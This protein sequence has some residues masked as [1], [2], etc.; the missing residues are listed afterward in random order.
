[1]VLV[2]ET[3]YH[4]GVLVG[5]KEIQMEFTI[6]QIFENEYPPEVAVWCNQQGNCYIEEIDTLGGKRRFQIKAIPEP[7]PEELEAQELEQAKEERAEAVSKII[8]E[9]D[10]M[11][12]DGDEI[13]Q[14]RMGRTIAAVVALGV[15][16]N[17]YTQTWVLADNTVANPTIK[18][19]AQALKLAG[20]EQTKLWTVPYDESSSE[21]LGLAKVGI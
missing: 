12:F 8:V 13:A 7:T 2:V 15:D 16:I 14:T 17:T 10:G 19:L 9:V 11:Q 18:Q 5:I 4:I 1:M 21:T 20:E 6:G 3:H